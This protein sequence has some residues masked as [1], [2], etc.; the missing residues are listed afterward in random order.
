MDDRGS[1]PR[2][3]LSDWI[4]ASALRSPSVQHG[5]LCRL[6]RDLPLNVLDK[7]KGPIVRVVAKQQTSG[8]SGPGKFRLEIS[9][10]QVQSTG[11][12]EVV[13]NTLSSALHSSARLV[14]GG[15]VLVGS[16]PSPATS[17]ESATE[18]LGA[19]ESSPL[20][21]WGPHREQEQRG[22]Q[23]GGLAPLFA[24]Y[25]GDQCCSA[26]IGDGETSQGMPVGARRS[27]KKLSLCAHHTLLPR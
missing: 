19:A 10:R 12:S 13:R 4:S 3:A 16:C 14:G 26:Q 6:L 5:R 25:G 1:A 20:G 24:V 15:W 9:K 21:W 8:F 27:C 7:N 2:A 22:R 17:W 18:E 11:I 23:G